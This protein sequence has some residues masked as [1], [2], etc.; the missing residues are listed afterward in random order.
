MRNGNFSSS[1]IWKLTTL[2]KKG[3]SFGKPALTYIKEKQFEQK[4]KRSLSVRKDSRATLWGNFL[5]QRV[6]E[7]LPN[8]YRLIGQRGD[9][10]LFH[11]NIPYWCGKPDLISPLKVSDIKCPEPKAFCELIDVLD[12]GYD[13][14]KENNPEYFW[15]LISNA[16]L[17]KSE[18]IEL[19]VYLP[20]ESELEAIREMAENFNGDEFWKYRFIY[21]SDKSE[22]AYQPEDSAYKNLNLYE[23]KVRPEDMEFLTS[24]V[25]SATNYLEPCKS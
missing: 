25:I 13:S 9:S 15:Q 5:E 22:L 10:S 1:E 3:D 4:L 21:E 2:D 17:T 11:E 14:F 16:I 23:F 20:Y 24:K 8:T 7:L 18:F 12:A 19:I 6:Y